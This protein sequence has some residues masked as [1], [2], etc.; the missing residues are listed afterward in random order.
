MQYS[1]SLA[2]YNEH[3]KNTSL[4]LKDSKDHICTSLN[5]TKFPERNFQRCR[6]RNSKPSS[7]TNHTKHHGST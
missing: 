1:R 6:I 7:K 2:I 4:F 5:G 3:R